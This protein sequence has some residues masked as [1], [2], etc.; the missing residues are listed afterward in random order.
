LV[1]GELPA[2]NEIL[3]TL[4]IVLGRLR[5]IKWKIE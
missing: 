5:K 1:F 2:N 3:E 4:K